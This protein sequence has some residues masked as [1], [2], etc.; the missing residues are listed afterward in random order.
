M[1]NCD[2]QIEIQHQSQKRV[3][4]I[5]LIINAVMFFFELVT[6]IMSQSTALIADSLDMLADATVYGIGLYAV[7]KSA[8]SKIKAA[9]TSGVFQISLGVLV[10]FD[11][12]RRYLFGSEPESLFMIVI[13]LVA[14]IANVIC[15]KLISKHREG[16]VHMRASWVFS[17]NDVLANIGTVIAGGMVFALGSRLPDL[18]IGLLI[19]LMVIRGGMSIIKDAKAESYS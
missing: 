2:C 7:G 12:G 17:K 15:L 4:I 18:L 8:A 1:S 10:V 11:V 14:L 16:E 3:L 19:S 6:G 5:L 13:G 9:H